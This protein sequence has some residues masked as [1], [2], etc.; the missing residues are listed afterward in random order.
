MHSVAI[1]KCKVMASPGIVLGGISVRAT[2]RF[3]QPSHSHRNAKVLVEA[4]YYVAVIFPFKG[5]FS[6]FLIPFRQNVWFQLC[7]SSSLPDAIQRIS[8]SPG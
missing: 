6:E 3:L 1:L 4:N 2:E 7:E 5:K 8:C